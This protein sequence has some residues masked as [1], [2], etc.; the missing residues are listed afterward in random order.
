[1]LRYHRNNPRLIYI[2]QS[3]VINQQTPSAT[4][5]HSA[6]RRIHP[7]QP[8]RHVHRHAR[9]PV[10]LRHHTHIQPKRFIHISR[11][12]HTQQTH[13]TCCITFTQCTKFR[14]RRN[15]ATRQT[16]LRTR[17]RSLPDT[18]V[19]R[20]SANSY[21]RQKHT[22]LRNTT[23]EPT[24]QFRRLPPTTLEI[25]T[26]K[27]RRT[28]HHTTNIP[29]HVQLRIRTGQSSANHRR[30]HT[31]PHSNQHQYP[32]KRT[33]TKLPSKSRRSLKPHQRHTC[34]TTIHDIHQPKIRTKREKPTQS[35]RHQNHT[36]PST[37][38]RTISPAIRIPNTRPTATK[39]KNNSLPTNPTQHRHHHRTH[40][41]PA[42]LHHTHTQH[43]PTRTEKSKQTS[44][45]T[46]HRIHTTKRSK[47]LPTAYTY[48]QRNRIHSRYRSNSI[49]SK[50]IHTH[51]NSTL[52]HKQ[53][54]QHPA[55]STP[56]TTATNHR[57]THQQRSHTTQ[58]QLHLE[59]QT[60]TPQPQPCIIMNY[61]L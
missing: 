28:H 22:Q 48:T 29:Q 53:P 56:R 1:M 26:R 49:P 25:H 55:S 59:K 13:R 58:S 39:P 34:T 8:H 51:H 37:T 32:R 50:P 21:T 11:L 9:L 30:C 52:T 14:R 42:Q 38:H 20:R 43:L 35:P 33:K 57:H 10:L 47:T 31:Q 41:Q 24:R 4:Y 44:D 5:Q 23:R 46:P 18:T 60:I 7:R 2:I 3:N 61:A 15:S 6:A 16:T 36:T 12:P 40:H 54:K 19:H 27:Q 17:H 45:T